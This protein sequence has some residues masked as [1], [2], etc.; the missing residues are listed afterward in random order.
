[1]T[2]SAEVISAIAAV[3]SAVG[4]AFA[5][6]AAFRSADSARKMEQAANETE[7]RS[8]L[9]Q[10]VVTAKEVEVEGAR[11]TAVATATV[12]SLRDLAIFSGSPGGSRENAAVAALNLLAVRANA[13]EAEGKLFG[14][15]P[16]SLS[17]SP[18]EE[19]DRVATKLWA[20]RIEAVAM[21]RDIESQRSEFERQNHTYRQKVI[22]GTNT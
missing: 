19:I 4:G 8:A 18:L 12:L 9:R 14:A 3:V 16:S 13:I 15:W 11:V 5:A 21:R 6:I 10:L 22:L 1:M 17:S 2:L 20:L 7:R